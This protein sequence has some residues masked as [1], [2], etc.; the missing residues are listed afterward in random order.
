[1]HAGF[2]GDLEKG[3][4]VP[5]GARKAN[6]SPEVQMYLEEVALNEQVCCCQHSLS[7]FESCSMQS[8]RCIMQLKSHIMQAVLMTR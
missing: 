6:L 5:I 3:G 7:T 2:N 4:P 1:M 8:E